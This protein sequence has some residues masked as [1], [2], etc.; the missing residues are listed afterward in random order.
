V[1]TSR[2]PHIHDADN[3]TEGGSKMST[4]AGLCSAGAAPGNT[5]LT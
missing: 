2:A 3:T 4:K 1:A 5:Q